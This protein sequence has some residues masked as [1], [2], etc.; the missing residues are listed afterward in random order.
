M[1]AGSNNIK[2]KQRP[3][4]S[5]IRHP[6]LLLPLPLSSSIGGRQVAAEDNP[7]ESN[8]KVVPSYA[9]RLKYNCYHGEWNEQQHR[10]FERDAFVRP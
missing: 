7:V 2:P 5:F 4:S 10:R 8:T 3:R 9:H 6:S 1:Q